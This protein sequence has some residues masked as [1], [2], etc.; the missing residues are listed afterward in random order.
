MMHVMRQQ[1]KKRK[2]QKS[3]KDKNKEKAKLKAEEKTV[4]SYAQGKS[5]IRLRKIVSFIVVE[6]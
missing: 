1:P 3:L 2:N 5:Q 4:A 6:R